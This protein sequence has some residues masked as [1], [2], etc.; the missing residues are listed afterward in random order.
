MK[1]KRLFQALCLPLVF[2]L[3]VVSCRQPLGAT[4][5]GKLVLGNASANAR[6]ILCQVIET[7]KTGSV[8]Q[9]KKKL[10]TE[11]DRV[12]SFTIE[13]VPASTYVVVYGLPD[14]SR[15]TLQALDGLEVRYQWPFSEVSREQVFASVAASLGAEGSPLRPYNLFSLDDVQDPFGGSEGIWVSFDRR[16]YEG[17]DDGAYGDN[18]QETSPVTGCPSAEWVYCPASN[19]VISRQYGLSLVYHYGIPLIISLEPGQTIDLV[20]RH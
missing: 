18:L 15:S 14:E 12:G 3:L 4:I 6:V 19:V 7:P 1:S 17:I 9:I 13:D 20:I 16:A 8:C 10:T 5:Q 2:T 11:T